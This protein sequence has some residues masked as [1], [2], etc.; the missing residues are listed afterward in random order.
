[1]NQR[2]QPGLLRLFSLQLLLAAV[3]IAIYSLPAASQ[4]KRTKVRISNAGFTITAL[5]LL[6]AK[7]WGAFA[8]NGIDV[9]LIVMSPSLAAAAVNAVFGSWGGGL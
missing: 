1:M 7:D 2:H 5:P 3:V 6:A 4:D 9:E 8:A